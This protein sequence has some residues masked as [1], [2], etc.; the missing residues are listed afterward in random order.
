MILPIVR[1][2]T[3]NITSVLSYK[4][5]YVNWFGLKFFDITLFLTLGL[6]KSV[7]LK[8]YIG[9]HLCTQKLF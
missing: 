1:I 9:A 4:L 5:L 8:V 3:A 6:F 2:Y 7:V